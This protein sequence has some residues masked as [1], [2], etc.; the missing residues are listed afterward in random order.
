MYSGMEIIRYEEQLLSAGKDGRFSISS[1][2][3]YIFGNFQ[4]M[5]LLS[6]PRGWA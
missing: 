4:R 1:K 5:S 6:C 3:T 2:D